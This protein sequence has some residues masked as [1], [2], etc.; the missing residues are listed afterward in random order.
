MS[1]HRFCFRISVFLFLF[2]FLVSLHPATAGST[3]NLAKYRKAMLDLC[4]QARTNPQKFAQDNLQMFKDDPQGTG[5]D[6]GAYADLMSRKP[7]PALTLNTHLNAAAQFISRFM[8]EHNVLDHN[9]NGRTPFQRLDK[10]GYKFSAAAENIGGAGCRY[11]NAEIDPE[12][13]A[14]NFVLQWI[15]DRDVKGVGHRKNLLNPHFT[16]IGIG[17]WNNK[18]SDLENY[19]AQE[20]GRP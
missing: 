3:K 5:G 15:I 14:L 12:L 18:N 6:N 11:D 13:A 1:S 9:A 19:S 16:E 17:F 4:N 20:F 10:I 2:L 7:V 8:A